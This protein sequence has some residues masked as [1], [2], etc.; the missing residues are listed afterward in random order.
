MFKTWLENR[1][2]LQQRLEALR[3]QFAAAAQQVYD[4]WVQDEY[5]DLNGGGICQDVAEAIAG[6]I[7]QHIPQVEAGTISASCGEQHVWVILHN[8]HEGFSI[9]V[10]YHLYEKGGGYSWT[11]I[12]G[13]VF[14]ARD[15]EI[16]PMDHGDARNALEDPFG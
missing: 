15:I 6:V 3:P 9:D 11:K 12:P 7:H 13:V 14:D 4:Q 10:P 5:D 2:P 16:Y 1:I 8:D